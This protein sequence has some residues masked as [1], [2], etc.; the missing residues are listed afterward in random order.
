MLTRN[1]PS[2]ALS[3]THAEALIKGGE[4]RVPDLF[5]EAQYSLGTLKCAGRCDSVWMTAYP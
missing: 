3:D 1:R 5:D 2:L 4:L